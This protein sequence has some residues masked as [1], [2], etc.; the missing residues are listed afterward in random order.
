MKLSR[1]VVLAGAAG[2]AMAAEPLRLPKK[3]RVAIWGF[4]GHT[5]EVLTPLPQLPDVAVVAYFDADPGVME[6]QKKNVRLAGAKACTDWRQMLD[7]NPDIVCVSNNNG[8]RAAA[9]LECAK[10]KLKIIAEK[11]LAIHRK[12]FDEIRRVVTAN[13][14][15]LTMMLPLR[16]TPHFQALEKIVDEELI[17]EVAL[18]AGQKSYKEGADSEWKNKFPSYGGTIPWVGIHMADLMMWTSGRN[19][20]Q[21]AAFQYRVGHPQ[22][23]DRENTASA[24]FQLDNRGTAV[25]TMDYLRPNS[26]TTHEDDRLRLAGTR[27]IA[28]YQRATG[29]TLMTEGSAP[30]TLTDL[31]APKHL[32]VEWLKSIY[33]GA[34]MPILLTDIW[35]VNEVVLGAREAAETGKIVKL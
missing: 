9:V 2:L 14:V 4:D 27:G 34:L 19:F 10:R 17:G 25:L 28:E 12:D 18:I 24:V 26:A 22:I 6:R 21:A 7:M 16:F 5:G 29:V 20:T 35:R 11:P 15:D 30:K 32:F 3:V 13:R 1:R 23:R 8:D 31:P 33:H